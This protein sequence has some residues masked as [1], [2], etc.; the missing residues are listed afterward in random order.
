MWA[1]SLAAT[2]LEFR[3]KQVAS[4]GTLVGSARNTVKLREHPQ[5]LTTKC[6][7]KDVHGQVNDLGY[8]NNVKDWAIRSQVLTLAEAWMQFR[9]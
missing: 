1:K 9:D 2:R 7:S 4:D 6:V 8:G 5:A 3:D